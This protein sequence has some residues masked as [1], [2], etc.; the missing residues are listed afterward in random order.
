MMIKFTIVLTIIFLASTG[1]NTDKISGLRSGHP[2]PGLREDGVRGR[3]DG[4]RGDGFRGPFGGIDESELV[5]LSCPNDVD[6]E[7][8][9]ALFNGEFGAWLCRTIFEPLTVESDSRSTC[10]QRGTCASFGRLRLLR[11]SMPR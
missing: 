8:D 1:I 3:E 2:G 5:V 10:R 11:W 7:P 6:N 4:G 9:C